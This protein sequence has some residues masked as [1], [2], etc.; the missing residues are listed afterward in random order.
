VGS[1]LPTPTT[2]L[3]DRELNL[4]EI[5]GYIRR[6]ARLLTLTGP[7]GAGKTRLA[8]QTAWDAADLFPDGVVFVALAP[9]G[10]AAL[11][12]PTI[13]QARNLR[14][15]ENLASYEALS[16]YLRVPEGEAAAAGLGQLR[17]C[18]GGGP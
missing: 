15:A 7:G 16:A 1:T 3:L 2:Q 17:A 11:V 18:P 13:G 10:N 12:L 14:E 5:G 8:I 4:E 9:L 6:E